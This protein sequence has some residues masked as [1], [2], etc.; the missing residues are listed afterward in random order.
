[1]LKNFSLSIVPNTSVALVGQSG[2]GKTTILNLL[3]RFYDVDSGAI[4]IDGIDTRHFDPRYCK[5]QYSS[6]SSYS[7]VTIIVTVR[8]C[9]LAMIINHHWHF[10]TCQNRSYIFMCWLVVIPIYMFVLCC[11]VHSITSIV[12]QEPVLF[13]GTI[14][15]N[16][17][18]DFLKSLQ[19]TP[20]CHLEQH[21]HMHFTA[22]SLCLFVSPDIRV[23]LVAG[24]TEPA[25]DEVVMCAK[26]ANAHDFIVG[27]PEGY[28]TVVGERGVR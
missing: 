15:S 7:A 1:M 11:A 24:D 23:R 13:S 16:I 6:Y 19:P 17:A 5:Q 10:V 14:R 28:D 27:F 25:E 12:P 18:Y 22:L 4:L 20:S 2:S 8:T 9:L 3:Q 21:L 26:Q